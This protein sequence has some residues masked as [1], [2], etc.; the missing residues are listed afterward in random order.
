VRIPVGVF[1]DVNTP[2]SIETVKLDIET[3]A[4]GRGVLVA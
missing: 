3:D 2:Y 4:V 1:D